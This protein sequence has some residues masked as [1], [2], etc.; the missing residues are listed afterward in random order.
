MYLVQLTCFSWGEGED[1]VNCSYNHHNNIE[2]KLYCPPA[3]ARDTDR[4]SGSLWPMK[5]LQ[6]ASI[7]LHPTHHSL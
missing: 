1:P 5:G 7:S 2:L 4:Q 3:S 6:S